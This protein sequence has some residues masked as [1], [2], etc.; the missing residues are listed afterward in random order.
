MCHTTPF[1][2][3]AVFALLP[4]PLSLSL[5]QW[6]FC[7]S[8]PPSLPP[9]ATTHIRI[10]PPPPRTTPLHVT[11]CSAARVVP[12]RRS[13]IKKQWARS[14]GSVIIPDLKYRTFG[15]SHVAREG[16]CGFN[17]Q[18]YL[19]QRF[20]VSTIFWPAYLCKSCRCICCQGNRSHVTSAVGGGGDT[21]IEDASTNELHE[22][23][24]DKGKE[25]G[26]KIPW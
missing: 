24:I 10:C 4:H 17:N 5:P 18:N 22:I 19:V 11:L 7:P 20:S 12:Q 23:D 13:Q 25:R 16:G 21:Q 26:S 3:Q 9:L 14:C 1:Y 6:L 8:L 2:D 15:S